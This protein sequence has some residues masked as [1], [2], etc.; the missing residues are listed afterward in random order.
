MWSGCNSKR[1]RASNELSFRI[2]CVLRCLEN[3]SGYAPMGSKRRFQTLQRR[4]LLQAGARSDLAS[5]AIHWQTAMS[6]REE[7]FQGDRQRFETVDK[8]QRWLCKQCNSE[9]HQYDSRSTERRRRL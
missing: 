4:H 7:L 8:D 5:A 9:H 2:R 3:R 6:C 1:V